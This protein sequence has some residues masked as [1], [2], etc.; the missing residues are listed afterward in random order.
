MDLPIEIK[1]HPL[2]KGLFKTLLI[3]ML[4]PP[5]PAVG[6]FSGDYSKTNMACTIKAPHFQPLPSCHRLLYEKALIV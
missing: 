2:C 6:I 5:P 4:T 1:V 3:N